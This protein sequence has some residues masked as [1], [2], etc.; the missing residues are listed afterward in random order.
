M[1]IFLYSVCARTSIA[2]EG[3]Q[4]PG[5][6]TLPL[7]CIHHLCPRRLFPVPP[8]LFLLVLLFGCCRFGSDPNL[9]KILT[10]D[11]VRSDV[12]RH[13]TATVGIEPA[14]SLQSWKAIV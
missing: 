1:A 13:V 2:P 6:L 8:T 9:L 10:S 14:D 3:E 12:A 7:F 4:G 5:F 11:D